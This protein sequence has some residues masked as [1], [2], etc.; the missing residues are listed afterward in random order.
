MAAVTQ[1]S[2]D[3][4]GVSVPQDLSGVSVPQ[5]LSGVSVPEDLSGVSVTPLSATD[6]LW[7]SLEMIGGY[8][9][10]IFYI[11]IALRFVAFVTSDMLHKPLPYRI[12]T[13]IY[14]FIFAPL[15]IPYYAYRTFKAAWDIRRPVP[16]D[17]LPVAY[18]IFPAYE[19]DAREPY[20]LIKYVAG[21]P[22]RKDVLDSI[23]SR[24]AADDAARIN[25]LKNTA[26]AAG[27]AAVGSPMVNP[28]LMSLLTGSGIALI[29]FIVCIILYTIYQALFPAPSAPPPPPEPPICKAPP[30]RPSWWPIERVWP[31]PPPAMWPQNTP[32]PPV[33][34]PDKWPK[35]VPWPPPPID[36]WPEDV[37]WPPL[38]GTSRPPSWPASLPWPVPKPKSNW[39]ADVPWPL[40]LPP[41]S[42]TLSSVFGGT[43]V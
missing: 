8:I 27:S 37:S 20:D 17:T 38:A 42:S 12:L 30:P 15:F 26:I 33:A 2:V 35:E 13:G 19:F 7:K 11:A 40:V 22:N 43:T 31:P 32:W 10:I 39:P 24:R 6:A 34:P 21:Y 1:S 28:T 41:P 5:D 29:G 14:I 4:S 36:G 9:G 25:Y 18:S 16:V 23:Q 3:L